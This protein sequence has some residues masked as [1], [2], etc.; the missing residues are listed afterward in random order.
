MFCLQNQGVF[1]SLKLRAFLCVSFSLSSEVLYIGRYQIASRDI[2][3]RFLLILE[4]AKEICLYL[5]KILGTPIFGD[6][7]GDSLIS[8]LGFSEMVCSISYWLSHFLKVLSRPD[9]PPS[10][11]E[12][13]LRLWLSG[14]N[15]VSRMMRSRGVLRPASG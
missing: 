3:G 7:L 13:T 15:L 10:R 9:V 12:L 11:V 14:S 5:P 8:L 2:L 1:D 6:I 4:L